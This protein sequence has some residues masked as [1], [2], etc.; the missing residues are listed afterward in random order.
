MVHIKETSKTGGEDLLKVG[1]LNLVDLAGSENVGRSGAEKGRAREAGMINA[2][3]LA[4]G[5][6]INKLVEKQSHIPYRFVPLPLTF[7]CSAEADTCR[8]P[9]RESKLTRL[10]QDSLGGRTKTTIIAT[11]SPVNFEETISTLDYALRAKTIQ[12]R[13]EI[14]Q[15]MTKGAL[16]GQY[17]TEIERLKVDLLVCPRRSLGEPA[18]A[19]SCLPQ[20][21]R[22]KNGIYFSSASW[23]E[24][25]AEQE[26]RRLQL[27][28]AKRQ[29]DI[30]DS[31]L[32]TTRAQFE[33]NLRLLGTREEELRKI[34]DEVA[35]KS[36]ELVVLAKELVETQGEL[37]EETALREAFE[38]SRSGWKGAA[39]E[40]FQDV[41]G[42]RAKLGSCRACT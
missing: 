10:L 39:G 30:N 4:L 16:L 25:S 24:L 1:K 37:E 22:E 12:N 11:I 42:L 32:Q 13:P 9:F 23:A 26:A 18:R 17:A 27:E 15:R 33:M 34:G 5:R 19:Y 40:A 38:S 28:E 2:S 14:N 7:A 20:A 41:D 8:A 6:V 21:A 35:R 3:L 36:K 29:I 31:Q